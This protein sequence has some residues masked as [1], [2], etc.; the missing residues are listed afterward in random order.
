M[1]S[2]YAATSGR[3][4]RDGDGDRE[5]ETE[6]EKDKEKEREREN[7]LMMIRCHEP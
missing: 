2:P 4:A 5:T 7:Y 6:K 1:E 3:Y